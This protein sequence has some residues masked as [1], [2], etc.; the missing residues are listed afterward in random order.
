MTEPRINFSFSLS[1]IGDDSLSMLLYGLKYAA[2]SKP[3]HPLF[4]DLSVAIIEEL[5]TRLEKADPLPGFSLGFDDCTVDELTIAVATAHLLKRNVNGGVRIAAFCDGL[6]AAITE[7]IV[8][9]GVATALLR[10]E[11]EN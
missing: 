2:R 8:F 1:N 6:A 3:D 11:I 9:R 4:K 10:A 5:K 7:E